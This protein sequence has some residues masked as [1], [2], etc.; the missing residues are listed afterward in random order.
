MSR[1]WRGFSNVGAQGAPLSIARGAGS[2]VWDAAGNEYLDATGSLWYCAVGYGRD[3]IAAAAAEQMRTL[4]AYS[5]FGTF[6]NEP[7]E[8]LAARVAALSPLRDPDVFLC[9]GGSDAVDTAIKMALGYWERIGQ[10]ERDI[11]LA[12][13][14]AYHGMHGVGTALAGIGPNRMRHYTSVGEGIQWLPLGHLGAF[15]D[16]LDR[17][18]GRVAAVIGEPVQG[19]GGV[20]FPADPDFWPSVAKHCAAEGALLVADE[21]ITGF[22]RLGWWFAAERFGYEPD[23]ITFAKQVTSG[24]TA[25]GGVIAAPRL[26]EAYGSAGTVWRH[27]Y[28]YGGHAT[29]CAVALEN[30]DIMAE[31]QLVTRTRD[32]EDAWI[33][34]LKTLARHEVVS[35]VRAIGLVGAVQ[36]KAIGDL[37]CATVVA[38]V[39]DAGRANG[40]L[41]R[42]L[43]GDSLQLSPPLVI[44]DA[45]VSRLVAGLDD[46]LE[47][48]AVP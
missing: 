41:T 39:I 4:H 10:P 26:R 27:G 42:G 24:Y 32:R 9:S 12:F 40:V 38:R 18:T 33:S 16:A 1:F 30:L 19:A 20:H 28:T 14:S 13:E 35:E 11:V 43:A 17:L 37:D 7:A 3:S 25:L 31:E 2:T 48:V 34:A 23:I 21:V 45:E 47:T 5:T 8:R 15:V 29:S 22:G 46:A 36:L 6:T 44:T